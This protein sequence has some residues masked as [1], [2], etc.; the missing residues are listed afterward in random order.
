LKVKLLVIVTVQ[1]IVSPP[2]EPVLLHW[3]TVPLAGAAVI[4]AVREAA[5]CRAEAR[6]WLLGRSW[7]RVS[8]TRALCS[9][10][11]RP[12]ARRI[13]QP[14]YGA[15]V[16]VERAGAGLV[17]GAV[18][19]GAR[20]TALVGATG[21]LVAGAAGVVPGGATG[22]LGGA[23]GVLGGATGVL[24]GATGVVLVGAAG[25]LLVGVTGVVLAGGD[26]LVAVVGTGAVLVGA[27][28]LVIVRVTNA[29]I[30]PAGSVPVL[31]CSARAIG[32]CETSPAVTSSATDSTTA[33]QILAA[34]CRRLR[35]G[36]RPR[37][38][39]RGS[40]IAASVRAA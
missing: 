40:A 17:L 31:G 6:R 8:L 33:A 14:R 16:L 38:G 32:A 9:Q 21:V 24:G 20:G 34:R 5:L 37:E 28:R 7:T 10:R 29:V 2:T 39:L 30:R 27:T 23:T 12:P 3:S 22:A 19:A 26:E 4:E 18:G 1:V 15:A 36:L 25:V 13:R 11:K 35:T